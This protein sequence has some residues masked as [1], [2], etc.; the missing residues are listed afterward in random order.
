MITATILMMLF[1]SMG[2]GLSGDL[3]SLLTPAEFR[4]NIASSVSD[5]ARAA[6][7]NRQVDRLEASQQ[8]LE[9]LLKERLDGVVA[10]LNDHNASAVHLKQQFD[11][12]DAA[13]RAEQLHR[14]EIRSEMQQTLTTAEWN[15]VF[16]LGR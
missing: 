8:P 15:Q 1:S 3:L 7:L 13:I 2:G 16:E 4:K 6:S 10:S 11:L 9:N 5:P 14:I 12:Y